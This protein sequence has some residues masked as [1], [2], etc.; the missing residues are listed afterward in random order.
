MAR[1]YPSDTA[2]PQGVLEFQE[3]N[4]GK[5]RAFFTPPAE[6]LPA[7]TPDPLKY[8]RP[9]FDIDHTTKLLNIYPY[10]VF[11]LQPMQSKYFKLGI[12]SM[13]L[14]WYTESYEPKIVDITEFL[15]NVLPAALVVD[16]NYGLGFRKNYKPIVSMLE[17]FGMEQLYIT[18]NGGTSID[19]DTKKATIKRSDLAKMCR[20]INNITQRAQRVSMSVKKESVHELFWQF[21]DKGQLVNGVKMASKDLA[22]LLGKSNRLQPGG[23]TKKEQKEAMEVI[24]QNGK[25]IND[26]QPGALLKLRNDIELVTLEELIEKFGTML[27]K[28]SQESYWQKLLEK[29]PFILNMAFGIPVVCVQGQASVGGHKFDGTGNKIADFLVRNSITNN[30][31]IVEIKTPGTKLLGNKDYRG[32]MPP[33]S[34]LTGAIT[35]ILDQIQKF[36]MNILQ[37]KDASD[38]P[39]L[40]SY[41]ITGVLIIGMASSEKKEQ[42]AFELF[43]GNSKNIQIVTFDEL[44]QKLKDLHSFL[45]SPGQNAVAKQ[46]LQTDNE[47]PF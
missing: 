36:Q 33:S 11:G 46:S 29:N 16:Y 19:R 12:I 35:Q 24:K 25:R 38:L 45:S 17:G 34:E 18:E 39:D 2:Q 1:L 27:A 37:I 44:L 28:P 10:Q 13:D 47:L 43:R 21:L 31:A 42:Q 15:E 22:K 30:A 40:K 26:E 41:S 14:D 7:H 9:I 32:I 8:K 4:S 6:A 20:A 3:I 23:A 5:Y